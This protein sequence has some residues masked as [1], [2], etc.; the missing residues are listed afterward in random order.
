MSEW[1]VE[2]RFHGSPFR[3]LGCVEET[4][5]PPFGFDS[6]KKVLLN[7]LPSSE[8]TVILRDSTPDV[9]YVR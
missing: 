1:E 9:Q 4:D 7:F 3:L 6:K 2:K 5:M 8:R